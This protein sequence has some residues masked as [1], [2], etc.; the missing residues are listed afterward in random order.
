VANTNIFMVSGMKKQ[1]KKSRGAQPVHR[2]GNI[3]NLKSEIL[4]WIVAETI[5]R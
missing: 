5:A 4:H 2:P 3:Q 1:Q